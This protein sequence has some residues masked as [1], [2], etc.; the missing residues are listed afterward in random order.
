MLSRAG[1]SVLSRSAGSLPSAPIAQTPDQC[2]AVA[3]S[4]SLPPKGLV[5]RRPLLNTATRRFTIDCRIAK[6]CDMDPRKPQQHPAQAIQTPGAVQSVWGSATMASDKFAPFGSQKPMNF[7]GEISLMRHRMGICSHRGQKPDHPNQDDFFALSRSDSLLLGVLDGHGPDGHDVAHFLQERLP[8]LVMK[9]LRREPDAWDR[10]VGTAIEDLCNRA[11]DELD[12][13]AEDSGTTVTMLMLD[14][15][16]DA[17]RDSIED[18]RHIR[19]RCAFLGDSMAV[20]A[21]RLGRNGT[22]QV[23]NL[24]RVHKP[25][26]P[27]EAARIESVGGMVQHEE[28]GSSS[29]M[30]PQWSLA[31]SRSFGD[32]HA[33]PWG[34]SSEPEFAQAML[35]PQFEHLVLA[36]SDGVWD[37]IPPAQAVKF[38]GK[39]LPEEAQLAVERLVSKAQIRWQE[40]GDCADDVT[41]I[42]V[43]PDLDAVGRR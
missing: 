20:H 3:C 24:T 25:D 39:F 41:A 16:N 9:G 19:L 29:L 22:W 12:G 2:S 10:V 43:W 26:R 14:Q 15:Q 11:K 18:I 21:R 34:L 36:C 13:K 8:L 40:T 17:S 33:V 6:N 1:Q 27:D 37:V 35:E 32:F 23:T 28:Y 4:P 7:D 42:L 38:V 31:M 5:T 30:T